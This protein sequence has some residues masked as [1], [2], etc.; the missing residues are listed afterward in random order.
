[1]KTKPA[2][3]SK[4]SAEKLTSSLPRDESRRKAAAHLV[5]TKALRRLAGDRNGPALAFAEAYVG[6]RQKNDP[7]CPV[8]NAD[9]F[10]PLW[11]N[12]IET[13]ADARRCL[14]VLRALEAGGCDGETLQVG[15]GRAIASARWV[16]ATE[17]GVCFNRD[18]RHMQ[19][20]EKAAKELARFLPDLSETK[21]T[22]LIVRSALGVQR[23]GF[24]PSQ[25]PLSVYA[26]KENDAGGA[27]AIKHFN[28]FRGW[29]LSPLER[30]VTE[31]EVGP[32]IEHAAYVLGEGALEPAERRLTPLFLDWL[33]SQLQKP[34]IR[35]KWTWVI[36]SLSEQIGKDTL[37]SVI[38][39]I[40]GDWNLV[41]VSGA[42]LATERNTWLCDGHFAVINEAMLG[43]RAMDNVKTILTERTVKTRFLYGEWSKVES[44]VTPIFFSN[45]ENA[46][47]LNE[48]SKRF[49]VI[50]NDADRRPDSYYADLWRWIEGDGPQL[51]LTWL[52]A[53]DLSAFDANQPPPLT[54]D[55]Q[56]MIDA[57]QGSEDA[58]ISAWIERR[59]SPFD[60][61]LATET[62]LITG[63]R[64][65]HAVNVRPTKLRTLLRRHGAA[66]LGVVKVRKDERSP[67]T[68]VRLW[69]VA[70]A[71]EWLGLYGEEAALIRGLALFDHRRPDFAAAA[72]EVWGRPAP[73]PAA[74]IALRT[75]RPSP[76][77]D[78]PHARKLTRPRE[79]EQ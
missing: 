75:G 44:F 73:K 35:I 45:A 36:V 8:I 30:V 34:G 41:R 74:V 63:L 9:D 14:A 21:I 47:G 7:E 55:L 39:R 5:I 71:K 67:S 77:P 61:A 50:V 32:F 40:I 19:S 12:L 68:Q 6:L 43:Y 58:L 10:E 25:P 56:R 31:T 53:R 26:V 1:M 29:R 28:L 2:R 72:A 22:A 49:V 57:N 48:G 23:F 24:N 38:E 33:G 52:K 46:L 20:P 69:A 13:G 60:R 78:S 17:A 76:T 15:F 62:D 16:Y 66:P 79:R 54:G 70:D 27:V 37:A 64:A 11:T 65:E 4:K 18:G 51:L 3:A 59:E 42:E